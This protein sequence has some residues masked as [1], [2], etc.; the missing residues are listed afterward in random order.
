MITDE[1]TIAFEFIIYII[2][3]PFLDDLN[4]FLNNVCAEPVLKLANV[5]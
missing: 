3:Y 1:W 4:R 2:E 5:C